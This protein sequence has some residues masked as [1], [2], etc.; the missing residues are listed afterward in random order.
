MTDIEKK[1]ALLTCSDD[2]QA[3]N[4]L[5]E[6]LEISKACNQLYPY[7]NTFVDMMNNAENSYIR[8]RGLRLIAYNA[9]W[10]SENKVDSV[11]GQWLGHIEDEKPIAARQCIKDAVILAKN[12]PELIG[13]ILDALE[14]RRRIYADAM[15]NLIGKDRQEAIR[16]IRE[17]A[18]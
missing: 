1:I 15:Q 14:K 17:F 16:K 13:V 7:F 3:Y 6:L 11:I 4:A 12:K 18:R 2:R 5:K 8:T 9:K 10:D